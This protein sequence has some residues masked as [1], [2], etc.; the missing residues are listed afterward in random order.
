MSVVPRIPGIEQLHGAQVDLAAF[1]NEVD[2]VLQ[3]QVF[4]QRGRQALVKESIDLVVF[5]PE[6]LSMVGIG[7]DSLDPEKQGVL[8]GEDI[9]IDA[10]VRFE[11]DLFALGHQSFQG[12]FGLKV[13]RAVE[14]Y[15][16]AGRFYFGFQGLPNFNALIEKFNKTLRIEIHIGQGGKKRLRGEYVHLGIVDSD[17][18]PFEG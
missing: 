18:P 6:D 3:T 8:Q 17:F 9:G 15:I 14:I 2:P 13:C 16:P 4:P 7:R 11:A 1:Q 5:L 12:F 10:R